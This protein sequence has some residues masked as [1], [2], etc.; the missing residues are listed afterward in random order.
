MSKNGMC[1]LCRDVVPLCKSHL[2]PKILYKLI[3]PADAL[4]R[5]PV[6]FTQT[7]AVMTSRQTVEYLLCT[8]CENLLSAKGEKYVLA[9]CFVTMAR[10]LFGT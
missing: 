9:H 2:L 6:A 7:S 4:H 8:T 3:R 1:A 10:F 5:N